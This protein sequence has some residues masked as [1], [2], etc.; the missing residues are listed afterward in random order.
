MSRS[1]H[2]AVKDMLVW[3][4]DPAALGVL[5]GMPI[6]LIFI[7][8]S[9]LGGVTDGGG[10][11]IQVGVVDLSRARTT[12]AGT[13]RPPSDEL[14]SALLE[15][16]RIDDLFD[17]RV[18]GTERSARELVREGELAA[19]LVVPAGFD[20]DVADG[21]S[22]DLVVL[23]DPGSE[24]GAG[25][26]ESIV[27]SFASRF[28]AASVSVQTVV[29]TVQRG[30]PAAL[31]A[32]GGALVGRA[33]QAVTAE[34]ALDGVDVVDDATEGVVHVT[35]I[36]YYGLS[37]VSMFLMFGA[38]F[39]AFSTI[40]ENREQTMNRMLSTPSPRMAIVAGKMLSVFVLG[41]TQFSLLYVFTRFAFGVQWG[42]NVLATV[43]VAAAEM[44]AVTGLATLIASVARTERAAGGIGPLVVQIQA[45]IGGAFF[46]I[47]VLPEWVQPVRYFSVVGWAMEGWTAIQIRG[48]GLAEVAT[49]VGALL[50]ISAVLFAVGVWRT[51]AAR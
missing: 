30:N 34:D 37:M 6:V 18:L 42:G 43:V 29:E 9:A 31:A 41:M 15:S 27:T 28:S 44:L 48:A 46:S 5:L 8:G 10:A 45:L 14:V 40:Q 36:D 49:P 35:A 38:M 7:L 22:V 51:E 4:R 24:T 2:I 17:I 1:W 20:E 26:W 13:E 25:I 19:V 23:K 21:R 16:E 12:A 32:G 3:M 33:V 39:G 47:A 50:A 11:A